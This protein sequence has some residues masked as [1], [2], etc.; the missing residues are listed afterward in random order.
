MWG[1]TYEDSSSNL[2]KIGKLEAAGLAAFGA[3]YITCLG[4]N[5]VYQQAKIGVYHLL[6]IPTQRIPREDSS[7]DKYRK[8]G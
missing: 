7:F 8:I 5:E 2:E 3:A 6:G 1:R 4:L